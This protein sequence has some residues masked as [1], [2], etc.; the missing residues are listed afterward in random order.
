MNNADF[1]VLESLQRFVSQYV[2]NHFNAETT[3]PRLAVFPK[4]VYELSFHEEQVP[5]GLS[6]AY[7]ALAAELNRQEAANAASDDP[8]IVLMRLLEAE[9][10]LAATNERRIIQ[11]LSEDHETS[12]R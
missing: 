4:R 7:V 6:V 9:V 12:D 3:V 5:S 11:Y 10:A 2:R 8:M 1:V